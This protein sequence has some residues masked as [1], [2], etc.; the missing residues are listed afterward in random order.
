MF[1]DNTIVVEPDS[2]TRS[3]ILSCLKKG[4]CEIIH[5]D[6]GGNDVTVFVTL[7]S[8]HIQDDKVYDWVDFEHESRIL[9]VWDVNGDEWRGGKWI[10]IPISRI[11]RLEQL[12]GVTR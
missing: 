10:Q 8:H 2:M 11:K 12:T 6:S 9:V 3:S 5:T 7:K 1:N 4:I